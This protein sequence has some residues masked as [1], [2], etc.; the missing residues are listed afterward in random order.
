MDRLKLI[1]QLIQKLAWL[2]VNTNLTPNPTFGFTSAIFCRSFTNTFCEHRNKK[3][4]VWKT[5]PAEIHISLIS[6]QN[7]LN[8]KIIFI[9]AL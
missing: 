4:L 8:K 9:Y 5:N 3:N 6:T 7:K 2:L 1:K